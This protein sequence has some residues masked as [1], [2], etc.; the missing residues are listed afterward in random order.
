MNRRIGEKKLLQRPSPF[1][2]E[3]FIGVHGAAAQGLSRVRAGSELVYA[4]A[5]Y[6]PRLERGE[7]HLATRLRLVSG[8]EGDLTAPQPAA[9]VQRLGAP[10]PATSRAAKSTAAKPAATAARPAVKPL[11]T[12]AVFGKLQLPADL[13]P[14]EHAVELVVTDQLEK[15]KNRT[16]SQW[17][18]F[19]VV[20]G[21]SGDARPSAR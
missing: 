7:A 12:F 18:V 11:P 19:D 8:S 3:L 20:E 17:V 5:V 14:G 10:Q 15:G 2:I 6:N 13:A 1:T 16:T 4:A 9:S 21:Q